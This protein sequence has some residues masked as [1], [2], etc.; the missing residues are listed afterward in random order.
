ML[1]MQGDLAR[2]SAQAGEDRA[3]VDFLSSEAAQIRAQVESAQLRSPITGIVATP[4]LENAAGEHLDSGSAFAQV[5]DL[6]SAVSRV[7]VSQQDVAL[8]R[9]GQPASIKMDTYPQRTWHDTVSL[10][11]PDAEISNGQRTFAV[12]VPITNPGEMLRAGM[13]GQAKIFIGWRPAGY[14]LLRRPA[15]WI[16]Q[17]LWN[18]IGW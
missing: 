7:A 1:Q 6:S 16:W 3:Q 18:W 9:L 4:N 11:S 2:G 8:I 17:T 5:L 10:I 13:S 12:E 14:V 15:L